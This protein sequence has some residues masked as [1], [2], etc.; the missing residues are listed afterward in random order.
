MHSAKV[1]ITVMQEEDEK[2]ARTVAALEAQ[3]R[4]YVCLSTASASH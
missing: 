4:T 3:L 1:L 2:L